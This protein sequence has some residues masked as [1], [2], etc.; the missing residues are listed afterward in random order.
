MGMSLC[1]GNWF[2]SLFRSFDKDGSGY[3]DSKELACLLT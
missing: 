3:L 2:D 1:K